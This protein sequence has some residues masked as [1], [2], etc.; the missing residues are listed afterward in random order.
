MGA[1]TLF[2]ALGDIIRHDLREFVVSAGMTA[3]STLL[4]SPQSAADPV[5]RRRGENGKGDGT[6]P[7]VYTGRER[8]HNFADLATPTNLTV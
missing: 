8:E 5:G 1:T 7:D 2:L 4:F 3:L 6:E